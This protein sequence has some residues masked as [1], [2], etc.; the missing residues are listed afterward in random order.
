MKVPDDKKFKME[1]GYVIGWT[2]GSTGISGDI[3]YEAYDT[4]VNNMYPEYEFSETYETRTGS[5][6]SRL[7]PNLQMFTK[8][9]L[10][11]AHSIAPTWYMKKVSS[12]LFSFH[13]IDSPIQ[14]MFLE[15]HQL[16]LH[17]KIQLYRI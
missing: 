2:C 7:S 13:N 1:P 11:K 10:F 4:T 12:V 8:Y 17:R 16:Q 3:A 15:I 9:H 14:F 5:I 6:F